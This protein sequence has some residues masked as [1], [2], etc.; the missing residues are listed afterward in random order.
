MKVYKFSFDALGRDGVSEFRQ[1]QVLA[2]NMLYGL[3]EFVQYLAEG[4]VESVRDVRLDLEGATVACFHGTTSR[5]SS[6][7]NLGEWK[8]G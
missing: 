7:T 5:L 8:I 4:G 1:I 3:R 2:E 6:L